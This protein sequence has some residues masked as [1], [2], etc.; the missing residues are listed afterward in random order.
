MVIA[1]A[2]KVCDIIESMDIGACVS[3]KV[4]YLKGRP[5]PLS[6]PMLVMMRS[7]GRCGFRQARL[8]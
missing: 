2:E 5:L 1:F 3:V 4:G 8:K 7:C 6:Q